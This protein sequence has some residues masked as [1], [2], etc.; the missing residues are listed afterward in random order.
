MVDTDA[1]QERT[2]DGGLQSPS[3]SRSEGGA[4]H[5]PLHPALLTSK[6]LGWRFVLGDRQRD[7][8]LA[9]CIGALLWGNVS[10]SLSP[11]NL[12][13]C[14][15]F[16]FWFLRSPS[17]WGGVHR[18]N[19]FFFDDKSRTTEVTGV[20]VCCHGC[21]VFSGSTDW[22]GLCP[23]QRHR[24]YVLAMLRIS[25]ELAAFTKAWHPQ[26]ILSIPFSVFVAWPSGAFLLSSGL[27]GFP[28][29]CCS[30]PSFLFPGGWVGVFCCLLHLASFSL[31][32][33]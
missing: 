27:V 7:S 12:G 3:V 20:F 6:F 5:G 4:V 24:E 33:I 19:D 17:G 18:H 32:C 10:G 8:V 16:L 28:L 30:S 13:P 21:S 29:P 25:I 22:G 14:V 15:V 31:S 11:S 1:P 26:A 9:S 23:P 2:L